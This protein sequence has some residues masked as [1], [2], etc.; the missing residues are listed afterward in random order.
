MDPVDNCNELAVAA[1]LTVLLAFYS[2]IAVLSLICGFNLGLALVFIKDCPN[3]LLTESMACS[4]V[5]QLPCHLW[6]A[7]SE[8]VDECF[9]GCARDEHSNHVHIHDVMKLIALLGKAVNVLT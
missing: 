7:T 8:L 4:E 1:P 5:E 3:G 2:P 6:F 9:I